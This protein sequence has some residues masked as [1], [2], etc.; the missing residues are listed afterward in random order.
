MAQNVKIM[1]IGHL[2]H[3]V[4]RVVVEKP[5]GLDFRPGQ[6]A[7]LAIN[8]PGWEQ[9]WR[10]FTFTSHPTDD[11]IEFNIKTYPDH[12]GVTNELLSVKAGDELILGDVYGDITYKGQGIFIAGGAGITPFIA[13]LNDLG[14][15]N[16][17]GDNKLIFANRTKGDIIRENDFQK[18]LAKGNFINVLSNE[19]VEGYNHGFVTADLIKNQSDENHKYYYLCGPPPMMNAV[20]SQLAGLGVTEDFI[21]KEGF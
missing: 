6:A 18:W 2:T 15:K 21:V 5:A 17:I 4:L 20:E 16:Q 9:E 10:T 8:K 14:K 19:E 3:D 1:S 11:F 7:D 13:I 12:E